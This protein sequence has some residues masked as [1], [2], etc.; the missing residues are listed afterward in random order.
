M[1][2]DLLQVVDAY[3]LYA[4]TVAVQEWFK[5]IK[6]AKDIYELAKVERFTSRQYQ[7]ER[8]LADKLRKIKKLPQA[9]R[10]N[11]D[12]FRESK[13]LNTDDT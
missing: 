12:A 4:D 8:I 1:A 9:L 5:A 6:D 11:I 13:L 2:N 7:L 10:D 3:F